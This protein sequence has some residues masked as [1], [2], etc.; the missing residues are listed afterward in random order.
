MP[1]Q[2]PRTSVRG[3]STVLR[4]YLSLARTCKELYGQVMTLALL[5]LAQKMPASTFVRLGFADISDIILR[6]LR[7]PEC[8]DLAE[9]QAR[10]ALRP[11]SWD[12]TVKNAGSQ[13]VAL[14][15][16]Q[17]DGQAYI[18]IGPAC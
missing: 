2:D 7:D 17:P 3:L 5:P 9:L 1:L 15:Q 16:F 10:L 6:L 14:L 4:E 8:C 18:M 13:G 12:A 11:L